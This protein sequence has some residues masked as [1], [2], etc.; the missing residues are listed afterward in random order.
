M[1]KG[2]NVRMKRILKTTL[3]VFL[4]V[5]FLSFSGCGVKASWFS[6]EQHVKRIT[7]RLDKKLK[8]FNVVDYESYQLFPLYDENE[9]LTHFLIEFEPYGFMFISV[10]DPNFLI[11]CIGG[12]GSMYLRSDLLGYK[13]TWSPYVIDE[14]NSQPQPDI[15]KK[16]ILDE[17]G[18]KIIYNRSPYCVTDNLNERKYLIQISHSDYICCVKTGEN[19]LNLIG[20]NLIDMKNGDLDKKQ[21]SFCISFIPKNIFDL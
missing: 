6:E 13:K 15:D 3:C 4:S 8:E 9:N 20:L 16:W 12:S 2:V 11:S 14:S 19:F 5:V 17:N 1:K 10:K 21:S 7:K 18:E